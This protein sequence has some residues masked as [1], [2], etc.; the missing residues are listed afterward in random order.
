MNI[1]E[2]ISVKIKN[3]S[4]ERPLTIAFL[5]DSVTHGCFECI[6]K[7]PENVIDCIYDSNSVYHELF[8]K[9]FNAV[10]SQCPVTII[11]A[12]ISGGNAVKGDERLERDILSYSPDIAVICFGLNDVCVGDEEAY[13]SALHSIFTQTKA[14]NVQPVFM[15]PN[16]LCT[17][18]HITPIK[19]LYETS[20]KCS[21]LQN[22][23]TFDKYIN[24]AIET[25]L[26]DG[27]LVCDCYKEWK[28]INSIGINTTYLL[29]N[30]INH[31]TR[32]MHDL[33][34]SKLFET[35]ILN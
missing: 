29:A 34:A 17:T 25:A 30:G 18:P 28:K 12:G 23:G 21:E 3:Y 8:R 7:F 32:E 22:N 31:P 5:G 26:S 2:K 13:I 11:N 24:D 35:I 9:K 6:E 27:V 1:K 4:S 15:T 19:R 16:M 10:F 14:K 20:E 33:F